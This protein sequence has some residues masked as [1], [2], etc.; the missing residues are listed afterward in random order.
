MIGA[1]NTINIVVVDDH[2]LFRQG[3]AE[4]LSAE[5]DLRV[6]GECG[7]AAE[8]I[9]LVDQTKPDVVLLDSDRAGIQAE[10]ILRGLLAVSP[11][12]KVIVVTTHDQPRLVTNLV[13]AGAD[14]YVLKSSTRDELL[15]TIRKV[16]HASGHIV[17]SVS[18]E[19]LQGL[20]GIDRPQLSRRECDVLSLVASGM[21]NSQI[22]RRLYIS[23]GTV[24]RHLTNAYTKLGAVSRIDAIKKAVALGFVSYDD[25]FDVDS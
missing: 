24:K 25:L 14:A 16:H 4:I 17:L 2:L 6:V 3:I 18:R 10:R 8:A 23:E 22:A 12:S 7:G 5:A 20:H 19:T 9:T 11:D 1:K 15:A 13:A 21:R